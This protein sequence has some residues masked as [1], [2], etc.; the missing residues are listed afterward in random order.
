M[1]EDDEGA[2]DVLHRAVVDA[3][4]DVVVAHSSA[5][6]NHGVRHFTRIVCCFS[7][8][9]VG[10]ES[11]EK[12]S[13]GSGRVSDSVLQSSNAYLCL[14]KILVHLNQETRQ[15]IKIRLSAFISLI[16]S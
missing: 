13:G 7:C 14:T 5:S 11:S 12:L 10:S 2:L 3:G 9:K 1:L 15:T 8:K 6:V 16:I 4:R